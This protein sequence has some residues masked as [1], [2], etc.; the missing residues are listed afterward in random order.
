MQKWLS[1][2]LSR[3][4]KELRLHHWF[5]P[6]NWLRMCSWNNAFVI[7][8]SFKCN[9]KSIGIC[10][11]FIFLLEI[12]ELYINMWRVAYVN[13]RIY[14]RINMIRRHFY[15]IILTH[16]LL[17]FEQ[18]LSY[19]RKMCLKQ[20]QNDSCTWYIVR[21]YT[22]SWSVSQ[23][24]MQHGLQRRC[25]VRNIS[26]IFVSSAVS[27]DDVTVLWSKDSWVALHCLRSFTANLYNSISNRFKHLLCQLKPH[28]SLSL[29]VL[30]CSAS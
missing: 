2:I 3:L 16:A 29:A 27:S 7:L 18:I 5:N 11:T 13:I 23:G 30:F 1:F 21:N 26:R 10:F 4:C 25:Y 15:F 24:T 28:L 19:T 12:T 14:K 9:S 20:C 22:S 6:I 8:N 17:F